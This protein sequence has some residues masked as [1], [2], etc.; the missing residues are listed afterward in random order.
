MSHLILK[1]PHSILEAL[2]QRPEDVFEVRIERGG[3]AAWQ[4]VQEA[5]AAAGVAVRE[6]VPRSNRPRGRQHETSRRQSASEAS[7]RPKNETE[8]DR[9]F[10]A[11]EPASGLWLALD[12]IQ[13]PHNVG[14]IF[15]TAAFFGVRGIVMTKDRSAP[16]TETAYDVASGGVEHVPFTRQTNLARAVEAAKQAGLWVLG[17]SEHAETDIGDV[18]LDRRWL[19][20]LGNE[21]RG[22]R[23]LTLKHCDMVCRLTPKGAIESLNVSVAAGVL[24]AALNR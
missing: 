24:M 17:A 23:R 2:R 3:S 12:Q 22:L 7:L 15:R 14:A 16:L 11:E 1:N 4:S 19:L 21:E 10:A 5:A 18:D 9:L 20:V 8:I 6:I 13:D